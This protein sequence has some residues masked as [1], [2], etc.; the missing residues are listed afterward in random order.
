MVEDFDP[1]VTANQPPLPAAEYDHG[2]PGRTLPPLYVVTMVSNPQRYNSRYHLYRQF[3][4]MCEKAG[5]V[6]CTAELAYGHRPF[7]LTEESN[8]LHFR[9]RIDTELWHKENMLNLAIQ[10]L[11]RD[12][13]YVAWVDA[14]IA[15]T[16]SNWVNE[17]VQQLQHYGVV[18]M[19]THAIDQGPTF[20]PIQQHR[21]F[22]YGWMQDKS[23]DPD[24]GSSYGTG[25]GTGS[26]YHPGFAWAAR[27]S[28]LDVTGGLM[29]FA[30][31]GSADTYMA[32]G[33]VGKVEGAFGEVGKMVSAGY[34]ESVRIWQERVNRILQRNVGYVDGTIFHYWH[35]KKKTRGYFNRNKV[36]RDSK[37]DPEFDLVKDTRGVYRFGRT[38]NVLRDGLREYFQS[39]REDS[40]DL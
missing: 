5:A 7:V 2:I 24:P 25:S 38:N 39:R 30:V 21:G 16:N 29:D 34:N 26:M 19:F 11:P 14:D 23:I 6:L 18:Q 37:F 15:F 1:S 13:K 17:T 20:E 36:L 33:F 12:W 40:I 32:R 31:M 27:K 3:A 10:H 4:D 35:G 8:P 22:V 28:V 9:Y